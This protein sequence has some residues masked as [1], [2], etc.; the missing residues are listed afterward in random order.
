MPPVPGR[1]QEEHKREAVGKTYHAVEETYPAVVS[2]SH[3]ILFLSARAPLS[4]P[5]A[6]SKIDAT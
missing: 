4:R 3:G 5:A 6:P 1:A 2:F